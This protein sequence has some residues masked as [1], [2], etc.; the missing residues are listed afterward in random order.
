MTC[1][2]NTSYYEVYRLQ[3]CLVVQ[4]PLMVSILNLSSV[5]EGQ[6]KVAF[7]CIWYVDLKFRSSEVLFQ[8]TDTSL[9]VVF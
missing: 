1:V 3:S 7:G 6:V 4:A 8:L 2:I 9:K 5:V